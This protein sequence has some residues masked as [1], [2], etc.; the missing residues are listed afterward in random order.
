MLNKLSK[1]KFVIIVGLLIIGSFSIITTDVRAAEPDHSFEDTLPA[2]GSKDTGDYYR[3]ERRNDSKEAYIKGEAFMDEK[4]VHIEL[5][6]VRKVYIYFNETDIDLEKYLPY[7]NAFGADID[8]IISSDGDKLSGEFHGV[9]EPDKVDVETDWLDHTHEGDVFTFT[10]LETSTTTIS[11]SY[12]GDI[13]DMMWTL[14]MFVWTMGFVLMIYK[15]V[16]SV[17]KPLKDDMV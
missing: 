8:I 2:D 15:L 3:V 13:I 10:D 5:E 1:L 16:L 12:D 6:N 17:F 11:F 4:E 14:T 9:P 7:I